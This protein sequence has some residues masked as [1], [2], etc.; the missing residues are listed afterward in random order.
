MDETLAKPA[1]QPFSELRGKVL[2]EVIRQFRATRN[3]L[4]R[5]GVWNVRNL[6]DEEFNRVDDRKLLG[7]FRQDLLET[8]FVHRGQRV[9]LISLWMWFEDQ[10]TGNA[11]L[12]VDGRHVI[13]D[14]ED[15]DLEKL[16][17]RISELRSFMPMLHSGDLEAFTR[18]K[19]K[20]RRTVLRLTYDIHHLNKRLEK[21]R[22]TQ[23]FPQA[24]HDVSDGTEPMDAPE[25]DVPAEASE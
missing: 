13:L 16:R 21:Y 5:Y 14:I 4:L 19:Y 11:P 8:R 18:V 17:K 10:L 6:T 23:G 3:D 12:V 24:N 2:D 15:K 9:D 1:P 20:L 25:L 7:Y 22:K